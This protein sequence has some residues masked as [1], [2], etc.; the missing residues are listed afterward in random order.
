MAHIAER[1]ATR[2]LIA[3]NHERSRTLAEALANIRTGRLFAYRMQLMLAQYL[4]DIVK[5]RT[6]RGSLHPY[7]IGFFKALG[8]NHLNRNTRGLVRSLLLLRW[9]VRRGTHG[10]F[11]DGSMVNRRSHTVS[12]AASPGA[13]R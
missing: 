3:H 9:F 10:G 8:L 11:M 6:R 4:L 1:T 2:A 12:C 13:S 7:P 5:T